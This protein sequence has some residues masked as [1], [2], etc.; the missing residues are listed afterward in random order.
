MPATEE[1]ALW[2]ASRSEDPV[3]WPT[4]RAVDSRPMTNR[5]RI[6]IGSVADELPL[7]ESTTRQFCEMR[8]LA[9]GECDEISE[10]VVWLAGWIIDRAY[11]DDPNGE[12]AVQLELGEGEVRVTIEDWGEPISSFGAGESEVP[13]ALEEVE[14]RTTDLRLVNLGRDGKRLSFAVAAADARP[15]KLARY[16]RVKREVTAADIPAESVDVRDSSAGDAEAI[17]RLLFTN[18]GLGYGHPEFYKPR[19]VAERIETGGISSSVAAVDGEVIGHHALLHS[20]GAASAESG[21][22]VVHPG[23][24]GLGVFNKLFTHTLDRAKARGLSA[25]YGRAVTTHPYSQRSEASNGYRPAALMLGSVP[26]EGREDV[27]GRGATLAAFLTLEQP[28][29]AVA[30]PDRYKLEVAAIYSNIGLETVPQGARLT[31][32]EGEPAV[33]V[34]AD[35][36]RKT[37]TITLTDL[38]R[39]ARDELLEAIRHIVHRHDDIAYCD[40]DL[41]SMD[42]D[43]LDAAVAVLR[44]YDFFICGLMPFGMEGHDR[45]RLQAVLTEDVQLEGLVL[46]SDFGVQLRD[47]VFADHHLVVTD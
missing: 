30:V 12:I 40:L 27:K 14:S 26:D 6:A 11:P 28:E 17:S 9:A 15:S 24:R 35:D 41:H 10:L 32:P 7:I 45:L 25:V 42:S 2:E 38:H 1:Q 13:A 43:Q 22:A 8:G 33:S 37:S 16:G 5:V 46:D 3:A 39:P 47:W 18:Y 36:S 19:W 31:P 20:P 44:E 4:G 34:V 23:Y 29:R 21:I